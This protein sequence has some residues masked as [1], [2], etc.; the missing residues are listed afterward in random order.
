MFAVVVLLFSSKTFAYNFFDVFLELTNDKGHVTKF[1]VAQDGSF[2]GLAGTAGSYACSVAFVVKPGAK[3][4][5]LRDGAV[6]TPTTVVLNYQL[7]A[8]DAASG[9]ATGKRQ[10]A[11]AIFRKQIDKA[12]PMLCRFEKI[13]IENGDKIN[14]KIELLLADGKT[15]GADSWMG[16]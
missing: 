13:M 3:T 8:R 14:G 5:H 2:S 11:P 10:Y 15:A 6:T 9:M 4:E 12:S 1:K 7:T 16:K